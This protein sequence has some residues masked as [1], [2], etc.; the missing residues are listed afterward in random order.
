MKYIIFLFFI[1]FHLIESFGQTV[2]FNKLSIKEG[3]SQSSILTLIQDDKGFIWAGTQDGLNRYDGYDFKVFKHRIDNKNSLSNSF[4]N[5]IKQDSKSLQFWIG[6]ENGGLNRYDPKSG[7][8]YSFPKKHAL[9]KIDIQQLEIDKNGSVWFT[10]QNNGLYHY[11][12]SND[13]IEIYN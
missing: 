13:K 2:Q 7:V 5:T 3:L 6:T 1:L 4:I 11:W 12:P 8:F 10:T 9:S